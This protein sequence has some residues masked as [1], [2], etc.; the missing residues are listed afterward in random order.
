MKKSLKKMLCVLLTVMSLIGMTMTVSA[1]TVEFTIT[2]NTDTLSKKVLKSSS[3]Y[4]NRAYV[5]ATYFNRAGS[6]QC[7]S[8]CY[9][10]PSIVSEDMYVYGSGGY[11]GE[12]DAAKDTGA[13]YSTAPGGIYY[14]MSASANSNGLNMLGR[15][16]P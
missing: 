13:Y 5:T 11:T 3:S 1:D 9:S 4:E 6:F 14:Y 15:F 12:N 2:A 16:T 7:M 10:K 8:A